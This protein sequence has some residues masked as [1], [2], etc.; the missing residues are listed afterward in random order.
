MPKSET[1][2]QSKAATLAHMRTK[3]G[4]EELKRNLGNNYE[5]LSSGYPDITAFNPKTGTFY[6][7]ELKREKEIG[8]PLRP[9]QEKMRRIL[10]RITK[11]SQYEVWYFSDKKGEQ[12]KIIVKC[13]YIGKRL[14][15]YYPR[16]LD[17][18]LAQKFEA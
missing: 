18:D 12:D 15:P 6:F 17:P 7:V 10:T 8:K 4:K 13:F 5:V 2:W 9:E 3:T 16:D 14:T 11:K 1:T